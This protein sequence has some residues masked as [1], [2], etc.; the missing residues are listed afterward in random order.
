MSSTPTI[1]QMIPLRPKMAS[2]RFAGLI[3]PRGDAAKPSGRLTMT[4]GG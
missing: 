2:F 3:Y 4:V 1:V